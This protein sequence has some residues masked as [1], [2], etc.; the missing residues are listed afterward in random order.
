[1]TNRGEILGKSIKNRHA[2]A[3]SERKVARFANFS[4][5]QSSFVFVIT[6]IAITSARP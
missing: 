5:S 3:T 1:M 4:E 2:I 6:K